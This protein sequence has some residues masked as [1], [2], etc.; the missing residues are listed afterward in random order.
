[1]VAE[2]AMKTNYLYR[3]KRRPGIIVHI[4]CVLINFFHQPTGKQCI[5]IVHGYGVVWGGGIV[6]PFSLCFFS[7]CTSRRPL[8]I[9]SGL[10]MVYV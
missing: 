2:F 9:K 8:S 4:V 10:A 3:K 6:G 7:V 1:M 5:N